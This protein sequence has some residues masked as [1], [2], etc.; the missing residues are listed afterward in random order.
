[1]MYAWG[2]VYP[3]WAAIVPANVFRL[4][5]ANWSAKWRI[6]FSGCDRSLSGSNDGSSRDQIQIFLF[7]SFLFTDYDGG[8]V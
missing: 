3:R 6:F 2:L 4:E 7:K 5:F 1:M 8:G